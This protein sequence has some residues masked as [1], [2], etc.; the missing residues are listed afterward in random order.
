VVWSSQHPGAD[1][2][3]VK[4]TVPAEAGAWAPSQSCVIRAPPAALVAAPALP[5]QRDGFATLYSAVPGHECSAFAQP[6]CNLRSEFA[7]ASLIRGPLLSVPKTPRNV[8][9]SSATNTMPNSNQ[10]RAYAN[11]LTYRSSLEVQPAAGSGAGGLAARSRPPR[12]HC[13]PPM[14]CRRTNDVCPCN[15][16]L[17]PAQECSAF[18]KAPLIRGREL[19]IHRVD[20]VSAPRLRR[21]RGLHR[22]RSLAQDLLRVS[23]S[24]RRVSAE[25]P[26]GRFLHLRLG[27]QPLPLAAPYLLP[28]SPD[29]APHHTR[30]R[31]RS[32]SAP[33]EGTAERKS[34]RATSCVRSSRSIERAAPHNHVLVPQSR[35]QKAKCHQAVHVP[36]CHTLSHARSRSIAMRVRGP[37]VRVR[38]R[39]RTA[40]DKQRGAAKRAKQT[41]CPNTSKQT[42]KQTNTSNRSLQLAT[43]LAAH[44]KRVPATAP[45]RA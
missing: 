42:D 14:R 17:S 29:T 23:W 31:H 22:G 10:P 19:G 7:E 1:S 2:A 3:P 35:A 34:T 28:S 33:N 11:S 9:S 8:P 43:A 45:Q 20:T 37:R 5:Y 30:A 38:S 41:C 36:L 16:R 21:P 32:N 25:R 27:A 4:E 40:S 39:R 26:T 13:R 18:A 44:H 6:P 24:G 15:S 12:H